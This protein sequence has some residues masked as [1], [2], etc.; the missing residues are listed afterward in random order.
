MFA[1]NEVSTMTRQLFA[2]VLI[3]TGLV[4]ISPTKAATALQC[5]DQAVNCGA[6]C[7]DVT[8]GAGDFRGHQNTCIQHCA[9]QVNKCLSKRFIRSNAYI[10]R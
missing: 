9:V 2:I 6:G 3:G 8:G 7:T 5:E 10:R 1:T 4:L